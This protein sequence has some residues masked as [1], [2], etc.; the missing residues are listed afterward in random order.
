MEGV[1]V[2]VTTSLPDIIATAERS[3]L[4][5]RT[6]VLLLTVQFVVL[7]AYAVLLSAALLVEHRRIDTAMLRSRGAG[8]ARIGGS[9]SSKG[10]C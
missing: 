4:A 6:G 9:P 8:P 7:A 1:P 5:S 2:T 10:C 3:L